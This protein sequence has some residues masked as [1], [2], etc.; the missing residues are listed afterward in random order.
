MRKSVIIKFALFLLFGIIY[1][2]YV[3][4]A[5]INAVKEDIEVLYDCVDDKPSTLYLGETEYIENRIEMWH[6]SGGYWKCKNLVVK[7]KDLGGDLNNEEK[8]EQKLNEQIEFQIPLDSNLYNRLIDCKR[9][10][11]VCSSGLKTQKDLISIPITDLFYDKPNIEFKSGKICFKAKPKL[12]FY[13]DFSYDEIVGDRFKVPI[14]LVDPDY[15]HNVYSIFNRASKKNIG[16]TDNYFDK[17]NP[18]AEAPEESGL[19]APAQIKNADGILYDGFTFKTDI[20]RNSS[21]S[22]IGDYTFRN[23]GAVG[24]VFNYPIKFTF[25]GDEY[26]SDLTA[27]FESLTSSAVKGQNVQVCVNVKS[28]FERDIENVPFKWEITKADGANLQDGAIY[29]GASQLSEGTID[30]PVDKKESVFYADFI[31]PDSDVKIKFSINPEGTTPVETYK[32]NNSIDSEESIK[33]VEA[34]N[35]VGDFDLD[36]NVLSRK[37]GF[38]LIN[39]EDITAELIL[40]KGHWIRNAKGELEIQNKTT[41][42]YH[43]FYTSNVEVNKDNEKIILN[44][45]IY[46]TLQ[47]SDFKDNPKEKQYINPENPFEPLQKNGEVSFDGSVK[48]K[49]KYNQ[50]TYKQLENGD[51]E[52]ESESKTSFARAYFNSGTDTREIKAFTYNGRKKMPNVA[53]RNFK[54]EVKNSG[55]K[56]EMLWT[57]DPYKFDV[58]RWMCHVDT[59]DKLYNWT[60]ID[61]QYKRTFTQQNTADITWAVKNSMRK[62]YSYDR[63]NARDRNYGKEYYPNAVFASDESLQEH[64]YPIKSGYYFNPLG[65]YVCTIKTVQ[66]KNN[67]ASTKEHDEL[68]NKI[69]NS[70]HYT[71]N[72]QYTSNGDNYQSLDLHNGNDKIYGMDMLDIIT[73][74]D[75]KETKLEHYDNSDNVDKTHKYFKQILEGY[76]ES[77]TLDS[78]ENFKYREYIKQGDIYKIEE[79]TV[80]TFRVAPPSKNHRLYTYINMKDGEYL[81]NARVN[82]IK[83]DNYAFNGLN[84][85]GFNSIDNITVNVNGTLYDDQNAIIR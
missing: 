77:N 78:K 82:N 48:R 50:Y 21:E 67:D 85:S 15:G 28:T 18:Y 40:P 81:I 19:I 10:K 3:N 45:I 61:G 55:W 30:I 72:M 6:F 65:E 8:L 54:D 11:V 5:N 53:A 31:M 74:Y 52:R 79:T 25:Y 58:I 24:I 2:S 20:V 75:K 69:K 42:I 68:V 29:Q 64:D 57:S 23:G 41:D 13:E 59:D 4:C 39:G 35:Y 7:D 76:S 44:P 56:R 83:L 70:F 32:D 12:H 84:I 1:I 62:L 38:P 26:P 34:L 14:P 43:D 47:R 80:I 16:A 71:S 60:K 73:D 37:I 27:D 22:S 63:E 49:Y 46:A 66:Y 9:L 17:D 36:Y 51:I 33:V